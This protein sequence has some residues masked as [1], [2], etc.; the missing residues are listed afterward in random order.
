MYFHYYGAGAPRNAY[1]AQHGPVL[2][3][4]AACATTSATHALTHECRLQT[5]RT[6][7]P[8]TFHRTEP[9]RAAPH[10]TSPHLPGP[11]GIDRGSS[12]E[13]GKTDADTGSGPADA[14][15]TDAST[16]RKEADFIVTPLYAHKLTGADGR[17]TFNFTAPPNLG[18]FVIRYEACVGV[19]SR[20][21][22]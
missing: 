12:L 10:L 21:R 4:S 1:G 18:A 17:A 14:G 5:L 9:H 20:A 19:A 7:P 2:L 16:V 6:I 15:A 22:I 8:F 3:C 13:D 11:D